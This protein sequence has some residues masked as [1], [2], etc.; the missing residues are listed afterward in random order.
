MK[1]ILTALLALTASLALLANP[2]FQQGK[3]YHIVSQQ[4]ASG[5]V[6]DG[7]SAGQTTP[8]YY[9][10]SSTSADYAYWEVNEV[11]SG[12]YTIRNARTGQYVTYDG[13]RSDNPVRR[14]VSMTTARD[15]NRSLWTFTP[16]GGY[17]VIRNAD[18]TSHIWDVRAPSTG[19]PYVVGTYANS[20]SG[21]SNQLFAFY[22]EQGKAVSETVNIDTPLSSA[23]DDWQVGA[24]TPSYIS[25][26]GYYLQPIA[27]TAFGTDLTLTVRYTPK[28]GW[29]TLAI[30]GQPVSSGTDYTFA[31]V[32]ASKTYTL[33]IS[34][35]NGSTVSRPLT[36]TS[37]PVVSMY[38]SFSNAY[39]EGNIIVQ[40]PGKPT[41]PLTHI[42]AK[43]R[44]GITNGSDKHKRNYH[45]KFLDEQGAKMD[46]K[47]F[48]LRND[49][50]WILESC[51]V[52]MSRIRNRVLTD[53]WN[54]FAVKPYYA[55]QEPKALTGTRGRFVELILNGEYRGIY[56]MTEAMDRKQMKLKKYDETT[57]TMHGQLWKSKDWS[58][59]VFMGHN[60]D[61]NTY[62]MA[63]PASANNQSE[64][65]DQYYVKYPDFDDVK[66]TDWSTLRQ[67]VNF[68]CTAS[69]ADFKAHVADYFD[70]PL[71]MDYYI[72][73]ETILST[74]NHGKNMYFAVYDKQEDKRITFGVWDM[75]ATTGQRWSDAYYH[76]TLMRPEQDYTTYITQNEHG[77]Y[78]LFRRIK[79]TNPDDFNMQVRLRYRDLRETYLQTDAVVSRFERQLA[80]FKTCGAAQREYRKWSGDSDVAG[81]TLNFDTELDYL[82]DWLTRRLNYLDKTRFRISELPT[83]GIATAIS[84][85]EAHQGVYT[86]NG[87]KVAD[88]PASLNQLPK[89]IYIVDGRKVI[90]GR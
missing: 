39:A 44:G 64:S 54:D 81:K 5:C 57:A 60:R 8:L 6:A 59:A 24:C 31:D 12:V 19:T 72:L 88:T 55:E 61:Q 67:A 16:Q 10:T 11:E 80:E 47:F 49:N 42:K 50:S 29:G 36:F 41:Y 71:V 17:Y 89:G 69:N 7:S 23:L 20:G 34:H 52:D 75:D 18:V 26:Q 14:Y 85:P 22:D 37:L 86:L 35:Q 38:G 87:Q 78:N 13:V 56:C 53:L 58:Y 21:N 73:M 51:Q 1:N 77:D 4:Y 82:R 62:P 2:G 40:E 15:G 33:S 3:R 79:A 27:T 46:Q 9:L 63:A 68:V 65:W 45:V 32:R 66:P 83:S 25:D 84:A 90:V 28:E 70:M 43:W 74:D 30:D 48:G 76:S